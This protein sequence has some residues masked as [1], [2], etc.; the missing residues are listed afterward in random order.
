MGVKVV[1]AKIPDG[2][3]E[4]LDIYA[5]R[6]GLSISALI[7]LFVSSL[8]TGEITVEKGELRYSG[9]STNVMA[10]S[11]D[12]LLLDRYKEL[13]LD[14]LVAAF[15]ENGYPNSHIRQQIDGLIGQIREN[16]KFNS[17]K[18]SDYGC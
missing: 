1:C 13:K 5:S 16:G 17:R 2:A 8:I 4:N 15:E 11:E 12:E 6:H 9:E 14:K 7:K 18:S 3:Y 10:S